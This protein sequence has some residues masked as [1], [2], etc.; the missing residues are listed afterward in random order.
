MHSLGRILERYRTL[1]PVW[2][3]KFAMLLLQIITLPTC[4]SKYLNQQ[5]DAG[6]KACI[7]KRQTYS[8]TL[9]YDTSLTKLGWQQSNALFDVFKS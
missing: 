5:Q 8:M 2:N 4:Q 3:Q 6:E 7:P 1:S 9:Q